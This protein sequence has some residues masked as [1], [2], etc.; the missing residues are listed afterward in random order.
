MCAT[1]PLTWEDP[2]G[3]QIVNGELYSAPDTV[4]VWFDTNGNPHLDEVKGEFKIT[5]ED[6]RTTS[7]GLNEERKPAGAV[8]YTPT[9]GVSTRTRG[10]RE[11]IWSRM[12]IG[13]WLPLHAGQIYRA[14]RSRESLPP[15]ITRSRPA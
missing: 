9:L 12:A 14:P 1:P 13:P 11:L 6:G 4:C 3:L 5:W 10:G 2:R 8:L 7:F 15:P